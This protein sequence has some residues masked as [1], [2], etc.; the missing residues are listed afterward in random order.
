MDN[1]T[2]LWLISAGTLVTSVIIGL[3]FWMSRESQGF[4]AEAIN[5]LNT[6]SS[7]YMEIT[8]S[9]YD[10]QE[11]T[12]KEVIRLIREVTGND[13][14]LAIV[15]VNKKNVTSNFKYV[16]KYVGGKHEI[17]AGT[18]DTIDNVQSSP[19]NAKYVNPS[20][21]FKGVVYKDANGSIICI[22]FTQV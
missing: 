15:V 20:G 22:H 13:A 1:A 5:Q 11:I 6:V 4:N 14:Y 12:G 2:K 21:T 8:A 16:Y 9:V 10:N 17:Q 7:K 18:V 3:V 19:H